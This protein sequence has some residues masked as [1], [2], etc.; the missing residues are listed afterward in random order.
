MEIFQ[1]VVES[2]ELGIRLARSN[3]SCEDAAN[4]IIAEVFLAAVTNL[5]VREVEAKVKITFQTPAYAVCNILVR[6][7]TIGIRSGV[8]NGGRR[9]SSRGFLRTGQAIPTREDA[10][11]NARGR[12]HSTG[13][14]ETF[15][16]QIL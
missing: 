16:R 13:T 12:R 7:S 11:P 2:E 15:K 1:L 5:R 10:R 14:K 3:A 8:V 6:R 4:G 9:G